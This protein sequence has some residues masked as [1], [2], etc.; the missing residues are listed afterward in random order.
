MPELSVV[1]P[2]YNRLS[3]LKRVLTALG[4]QTFPADRFEVVVVSDGCTD[5]TNEYLTTVQTAFELVRVSQEN[6][7][8]AMARNRGVAHARADLILFID[9]DVVPV[10]ELME[11][12]LKELRRDDHVVVL[13]PML[14]PPDV[15]L[16]PW[17]RWEERMLEKQYRDM[18][19][20]R[21]EPTARQFYTGN[22]SLAR[23]HI[24]AAGG[25]DP[26]FHRAE[27]VELAYRLKDMGLHF[28]FNPKA[29][30]YH[31]AERSFV[32]WIKIP[33]AYGRYD[34]VMTRNKGQDWLLPTV[35]REFRDRHPFIRALTRLCLD[36]PRLSQV[37]IE[38]LKQV[39]L[40]GDRLGV[41]LLPRCA[42]SGIF[43]LRHYQGIADE[44]GGAA[45]FWQAAEKT[46]RLEKPPGP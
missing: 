26:S 18:I 42:F 11:E 33:Y 43:N 4:R 2:T 13:G 40:L 10:P 20:G 17:V 44:L 32:S 46:A 19:E 30:G 8:V 39:A 3:Q 27:D 38:L 23:R 14:P 45:A 35:L 37:A 12:H 15:K 6:Q 34:V 22:T 25:F 5:G 41:E 16:A 21:W 1:L 36:R 9:D 24:L 31:Y 28:V 7:G 29:V